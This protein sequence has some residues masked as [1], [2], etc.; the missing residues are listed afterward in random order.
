MPKS[1]FK[2]HFDLNKFVPK[3]KIFLNFLIFY[4]INL[5]EYNFLPFSYHRFT[6]VESIEKGK[7]KLEK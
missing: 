6:I 5:T 2:F 7:Q 3:P 4:L 1:E